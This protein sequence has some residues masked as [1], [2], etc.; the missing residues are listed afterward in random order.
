LKPP[1]DAEVV[2]RAD[3][4]C[5]DRVERHHHAPPEDDGAEKIEIT[6]GHPRQGH[7]RV[8]AHHHDIDHA[9]HHESDLHERHRRRETQGPAQIVASR[10]ER[11]QIQWTTCWRCFRFKREPRQEIIS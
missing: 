3:R 7:A 8:M 9:H 11:V 2:L 1:A 4:L 10:N 6:E 5:D